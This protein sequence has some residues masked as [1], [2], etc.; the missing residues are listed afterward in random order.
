MLNISKAKKVINAQIK[1]IKP[2]K[3]EI[4]KIKD[5]SDKFTVELK[6]RL[7]QKKIKADVFIGGSLAKNTL[8]KTNDNLYDVDIFVRFD[9]KYKD[10]EISTLLGKVIGKAK[11]VHGSRD[12][13]QVT[14]D[15]IILEVIPVIKISKPEQARNV[16]DLSYFHVKYLLKKIKRNKKLSDEIVVAK[17]FCHSQ[18]CYGAESYIHGFSGYSIE[19]LILHYKSFINFIK[20]MAKSGK[21]KIIIDDEKFFRN[22]KEILVEVNESK[23]QSPI[24]LID[25]TFKERNA[26]SGL[27]FDT[28]SEFKRASKE[29]L[30]KPD[31]EFFKKKSVY[32]EFK[33]TG[34]MRVVSVKTTKQSGDIS[35]TKS[36]KFFDFFISHISKDFIVKKSGF[37]YDENKNIAY[38]YLILD[39]KSEEVIRGPPLIKLEHLAAFKAAH[40]DAFV[41]EG[42]AYAH[43][44]HKKSFESWLKYFLEKYKKITEEMAIKEIKLVE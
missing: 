43:A 7:K 18:N 34:G 1:L 29:F 30:E 27:S 22:K 4:K 19:L 28:F 6:K 32:C 24:I 21:E 14:F 33:D 5:I 23:L 25:P 39:K 35:G 15:N 40:P 41:K 2:E 17:A 12:Y 3:K 11:K 20:E 10:C 37:D 8:V 16:T 44:S 36:K 38:Y 13:Y 9:E 26:L 42:V 31:S